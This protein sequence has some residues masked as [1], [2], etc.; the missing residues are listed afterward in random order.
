MSHRVLLTDYAWNDLDIEREVLG[1]AD[2]ELVVAE[3]GDAEH[4]VQLADGCRAIMTNW[5]KVPQAVIAACDDCQIV[6]RLGVGLDNIDVAY[7]TQ[8]GIP[9]TNVPDYCYREVAEHAVA[10]ALCLA[11]QL[12]RYQDAKTAGRYDF[13]EFF[14]LPRI[15][16]QTFGVVGYGRI[17]RAV[18]QR[19]RGLGM[20]VLVYNRSPLGDSDVEQA[21][22]EHVLRESDYVSLSLPLVAETEGMIG[23]KQFALM[24]PT[25]YLINA[26]RGGL[27]D[28][29]ALADALATNRLAGAGLDVHAP[30]PPPLDRAPW[31]DPRVLLTPHTAFVSTES[32][33]DLRR[34][35]SQQVVDRLAGRT[36]ENV[37]NPE[38]LGG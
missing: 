1:A 29:A 7:C 15:E 23:A 28:H 38:V 10:M 37:R 16:G 6:A 24:K 14:P 36:P 8:V 13:S 12:H 4:L 11:R 19:A 18:A 34:R 33:A 5:A 27:V 9:V 21:P 26:A 25:A 3:A 20:R 22:L 30:E 32:L 35:V 17:G 2:A 31:N